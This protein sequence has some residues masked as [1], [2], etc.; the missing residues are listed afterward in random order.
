MTFQYIRRRKHIPHPTKPFS[1]KYRLVRDTWIPSGL[2]RV[3]MWLIKHEPD[4]YPKFLANVANNKDEWYRGEGS[5]AQEQL[6]NSFYWYNTPEGDNY[7]SD[8]QYR[9]Q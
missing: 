2:K 4:A 8:I 5:S 3:E 6:G 7:W 1:V 9:M